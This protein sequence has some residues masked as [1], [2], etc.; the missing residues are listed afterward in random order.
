MKSKHLPLISL[1]FVSSYALA[2]CPNDNT[3]AF[4]PALDASTLTINNRTL[5]CTTVWGGEYQQVNNITAGNT[6]RV[7]FCPNVGTTNYDSYLTI[8]TDAGDLVAFNDNFCGDDPQ[9]DF[10]APVNGGYRILAD[11]GAACDSNATNTYVNITLLAVGCTNPTVPTVSGQTICAGQQATLSISSGALNNATHWQWYS[12]SCGGTPVGTGTSIMVSPGSTTTYYVR[13]EGGCVS[14]GACA[15]ATVTVNAPPTWYLDADGDSYY[16]GPPVMACI[17]PGAGYVTTVTGGGDCDDANPAV[18]PGATEICNGIDDNC[19]TQIDENGGCCPAPGTIWYVDA[20]AAPGGT[21]TSWDCAF[22]QIQPAIN[23]A[24]NGHQILVAAGTYVE[25]LFVNKSLTIT[26]VDGRDLTFVH[27]ATANYTLHVDGNAGMPVLAGNVSIEGFTF[28]DPQRLHWSVVATDHIATGLLLTFRNNRVTDGNRYGWW[29]YHSHGSL[30]CE[31]NIFSDVYYGMLLEGWDT[32]TLTIQ[33]NEF[34]NLHIYID[35]MGVPVPAFG[36]PV[37][38]LAMTYSAGGGVD[39]TNP[40][41]IFENHFHTYTDD[42]FGIVF[43]GGLTGNGSAKYTDVEI[44]RNTIAPGATGTGIRLRNLPAPNNS[45]DGGVHDAMVH[46]NFVSNAQYGIRLQGD[47]PGTQVHENSLVNCSI[48]AIENTGVPVMDATCNW[49]GT[50]SATG[51]NPQVSSNVTYQSWLISGTDNAPGTPGFQPAPG[52]CTGCPQPVLQTTINANV[53]TA[54]NDGTDDTGSFSVCNGVSIQFD[55]FSDISGLG[56]SGTKVYQTATYTNVNPTFCNNC[57]DLLSAYTSMSQTASL[58]NP[59][60]SGTI[61]L[62]FRAWTDDDDNDMIDAGEC[63]G[64]WVQY[65]I[66]VLPL[67][68]YY[69]DM[70]GD[71][72]GDPANTTMAC[73]VP[74]GYVTNNTDCDDNDPLEFPGQ[75][76]Y[77]D[78]DNDGYSSG[79]TLTQCLRPAGYKVPAELTATTGDCNDNNP[80]INPAATEICDGIDNDCDGMTD[81]EDPDLMSEPLEMSCPATQTLQLNSTCS[82][83]LPDYRNLANILGGCGMVTVTQMPL[84][85]TT[86]SQA[87]LMTVALTATDESGNSQTCTFTV[88]KVDNTPPTI[89]CFNQ[90]LTFNGETTIMLNAGSLVDTTDNCG[91]ATITLSPNGISCEQ[92]GQ[93]VPVTVT[94][95]DVNG[96]PATC[97][98]NITV[99]GLPCGWSQN[100]NGVN[101]ANGNSIAYNSGTGVWTATSTNCFYGPPFTSDAT[102]F[103]Q[104]TLC[105]DGSITAEV[106]DI[107]GTALGWAGVIMRESNAAGAKKAQLMT[108]LSSLSRREFRTTTNGAANPQQFPSQSRYWLRI[109]RAGNQFSMYVSANGAAW[110]FVGAQNIPMNSCIQMG[111][112]ATNYTSNSTVTATFANVSFTGSNVPPLTGVSAPLNTL[113]E[114][115]TDNSQQISDFQTYPNPTSGELNLNLEQYVGRNARIEVYSL[116][117]QLL[118]F[119]EIE[120]VQTAVEQLD[121]SQLENGM[122]LV[123]V[124]CIGTR[125]GI[126][127][128]LP[129]ATRRVVLAR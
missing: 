116:T 121:M 50:A 117:G 79:T 39:C 38:I 37:G 89:Q 58:V 61:V 28:A 108:N 91:V 51:V 27:A 64:D 103:A 67:Q 72:F 29:D 21:G 49:F 101:C 33:N 22:Q 1:L 43:N 41:R 126:S 123:K 93:I 57:A 129:D 44:A 90:T 16:T 35:P 105:G 114:L 48:L 20:S 53:V 124:K 96:N 13:G 24:G 62:R 26:G 23:A 107:S 88:T 99:A 4:C 128:E 46:N 25:N 80:D 5:L 95:T 9:V 77:A 36:G 74:M 125:D 98:S 119:V 42:G 12:G 3:S 127:R 87:G 94:V 15:S 100:P 68:T 84:G 7:D 10:V 110:Y 30:L 92:L 83:T 85:G 55:N 120:E 56:L 81:V 32:G 69:R 54:N 47:N 14:G 113:N 63:A 111:L 76:W 78:V 112:V 97:T 31:N 2:Q 11:V 122:Y 102:A 70:D 75:V 8:Y 40:Y 18:N 52:T 71:G 17:S 118:R 59:A 60:L 66:T 19:D 115:T 6:Y 104:R 34:T 45:P 65:T 82:A 86:V 106:T 73:S 109:V